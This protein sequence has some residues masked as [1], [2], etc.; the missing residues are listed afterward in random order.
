MKFG[1]QRSRHSRA[2]EDIRP[3][4]CDDRR[5][6]LLEVVG[7]VETGALRFSH[8]IE[9]EG[10]TVFRHAC[11]LGMEGIISKLRA[12]PYRA[13]PDRNWRKVKCAGYER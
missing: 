11:R 2:G 4:R 8:D 12:A 10:P 13:G 1:I 7:R 6:A 3:W 9:G 5:E